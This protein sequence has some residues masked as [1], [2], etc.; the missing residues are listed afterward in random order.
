[1]IRE[2]VVLRHA[3]LIMPPGKKGQSQMTSAQVAKTK[4]IANRRIVV[5]QAIRRLKIFRFLRTEIPISSINLLD[6]CL[7][8]CCAMSNL[9][10]PI[11]K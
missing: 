10:V 5:E 8:I 4:K 11:M 9:M 2:E 1:M 6:D 3:E 7:I